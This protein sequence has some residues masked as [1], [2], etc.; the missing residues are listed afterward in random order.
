MVVFFDSRIWCNIF[1][2]R[3]WFAFSHKVG[4]TNM[5]DTR[6]EMMICLVAKAG[7][8]HAEANLFVFLGK[9]HC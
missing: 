1:R 6:V 5:C 3:A 7:C 9:M 4:N 8:N 2:L